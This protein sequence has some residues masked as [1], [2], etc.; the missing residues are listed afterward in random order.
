MEI[1]KNIVYERNSFNASSDV[2]FVLRGGLGRARSAG[3]ST[4]GR[5]SA[6]CR[7]G[8]GP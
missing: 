4:H 2:L 7:A 5:L 3:R 1:I 6:M 8:G